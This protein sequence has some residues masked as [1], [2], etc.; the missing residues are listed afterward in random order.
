[1]IT[2]N[3]IVVDLSKVQWARFGYRNQDG[4]WR[5]KL[6]DN[7]TVHNQFFTKSEIVFGHE[8]MTMLDYAMENHLLDIWTAELKL[9]LT[10][11]CCLTYTGDKAKSL[12]K[13]YC[14]RQFSKK[15]NNK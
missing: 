13:A 8:A 15:G 10:A 2:N 7:P 3:K 1:M 4:D 12:W 9:K 5:D 14:E 11:N 6:P